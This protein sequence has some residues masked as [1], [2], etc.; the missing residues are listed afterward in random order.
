ML[1]QVP[2]AP[3]RYAGN[4]GWRFS[5]DLHL[6]GQ[7]GQPMHSAKGHY[8]EGVR[9]SGMYLHL[10]VS[11]CCLFRTFRTRRSSRLPPTTCPT[12]R[13]CIRTHL[14]LRIRSGMEVPTLIPRRTTL[15]RHPLHGF[16]LSRSSRLSFSLLLP[17]SA[18]SLERCLQPRRG[19]MK[20][21]ARQSTAIQQTS[22]PR[23]SL[24]Y[25]AFVN[26]NHVGYA[27]NGSFQVRMPA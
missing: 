13:C 21:L 7:G 8:A 11:K 26:T 6:H 18:S 9:N 10:K 15:T 4:A 14:Q 1:H 24:S 27:I 5:G 2:Q 16:I 19:A 17:N 20:P 22:V 12:S 25:S 3:E 23:D